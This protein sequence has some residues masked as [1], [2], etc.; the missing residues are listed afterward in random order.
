MLLRYRSLSYPTNLLQIQ[1]RIKSPLK[2]I[3]WLEALGPS[4][5]EYWLWG[6]GL[7]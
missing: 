5:A 4:K 2:N 3:M 7:A 6:T 1:G